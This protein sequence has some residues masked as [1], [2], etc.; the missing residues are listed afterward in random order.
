MLKKGGVPMNYIIEYNIAAVCL[1][2]VLLFLYF[3]RY[4]YQILSNR[5]YIA[6]L[7]CN[8]IAAVTDICT[9]YTIH[10][11]QSVPS[12]LNYF[13]NIVYLL[14]YNSM[15]VLFFIYVLD[16]AKILGKS[17]WSSVV[18]LGS[19]SAIVTFIVT[20]PFTGW[21]IYFDENMNYQHG[22]LWP[23]LYVI[24]ALL[25][26]SVLMV[27]VKNKEKI[28]KYQ[29]IAIHSFIIAIAVSVIL[30]IIFPD[31]LINNYACALFMV[32]ISVSLQNSD[33]FLEPRSNCFN[34]AALLNVV[35]R[36]I[37]K[38]K[39]FTVI[40]VV[41]DDFKYINQFLGTK[42]GDAMISRMALYLT[43]RYGQRRIFHLSGCRFAVLLDDNKF[44][45][46]TVVSDLKYYF[47]L[48]FS[49]GSMEMTLK[50]YICVVNY[51]DFVSTAEDVCDAIEYSLT[52]IAPKQEGGVVIASTLSLDA[53]RRESQIIHILK[54]AIAEKSFEVYYQPIYCVET[55]SF[56][57]AEAL[58]RLKSEELGFISP[59][60]F[61]PLAERTGMI[62]EIGEIVVNKVC[63]FLKSNDAS[64]L[65]IKYV[66]VNL[67]VV[68]CMQDNLADRMIS[69]MKSYSIATNQIN[70]EITETANDNDDARKSN[71]K[72][73]IDVGSTFSMDDYGT[74]FSTATYLISL[75]MDIVKIDKSI[76]W[77]AM[78]NEEAFTILNHTVQ[79]LKALK[80]KI[81]VEGVETQEMADV[82]TQMGCDY[83]QGYLY[84]KPIPPQQFLQFMREKNSVS[85]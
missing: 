55:K 70:F 80:K 71:E 60:E 84:S 79:M 40:A 12:A 45:R 11:A 16:L 69:I 22:P 85:V 17:R 68:Q 5:L 27:V 30:Q 31:Y 20:T 19:A 2:V 82:L 65:G 29:R 18:A 26:A 64:K 25:L 63:D 8:L 36:L 52:D 59:G 62:I 24:A 23:V 4:N 56:I 74:G 32:L 57:S 38:E 15:A 53:K 10:Y 66:E 51:P 13:V 83:F 41:P 61:I 21:I 39:S 54:N 48:P 28:S 75:P 77:S 49:F 43:N 37:K 67:S 44:N 78:K 1:S 35:N 6:M 76:L 33:G 14:A 42:A 46:E 7:G 9:V 58:L 34:T 73:L 72:Q 47:D 50:P 81:V 3:V